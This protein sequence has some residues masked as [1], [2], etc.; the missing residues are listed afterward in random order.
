MF[1]HSIYDM[2]PDSVPIDAVVCCK[3]VYPASL[4]VCE[5]VYP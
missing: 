5:Y 4:R 1:P 2:S 3:Y